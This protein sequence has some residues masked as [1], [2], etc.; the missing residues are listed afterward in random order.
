MESQETGL[1]RTAS[2]LHVLVVDDNSDAADT[3]CVLLRM[4]GQDCRVAYDGE[5]G[6]RLA[7]GYHPDCLLLDLAMPRMDGYT[8]ARKLR[9]KPELEHAKLIA[10]TTHVGEPFVR[11]AWD[12]G[13]D[14]YFPK[15]ADLPELNRLK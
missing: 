12:A 6:F 9:T 3:L 14:D 8:L 10:L 1:Q 5:T 4:W 13:F 7:C 15:P 11:L 2:A